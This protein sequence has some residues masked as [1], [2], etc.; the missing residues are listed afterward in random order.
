MRPWKFF[1]NKGFHSATT[2]KEIAERAG[3]GKGTVYRYFETKDKLFAE[4]V[5]LRLPH[6]A[7]RCVN[8]VRPKG[9]AI[10]VLS[11]ACEIQGRV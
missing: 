8:L 6:V 5:R 1:S 4:L 11:R 9:A 7:A 3:V 10:N 2:G